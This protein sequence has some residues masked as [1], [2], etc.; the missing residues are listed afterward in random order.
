MPRIGP[1]R[2]GVFAPSS[3]VPVSSL[4]KSTM[5]LALKRS[6][7]SGVLNRRQQWR[8]LAGDARRHA[9][10]IQDVGSKQ[11]ILHIADGYEFLA[12]WADER[13][14]EDQPFLL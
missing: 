13:A 4:A 8:K 9:A 2:A 3:Y 10:G 6:S 11:A 1:N 14:E 7:K 12:Q 5:I